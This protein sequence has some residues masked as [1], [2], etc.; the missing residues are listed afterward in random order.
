M[1]QPVYFLFSAQLINITSTNYPECFTTSVIYT[2][3]SKKV[4][5]VSIQ[6]LATVQ[7]QVCFICKCYSL[8]GNFILIKA[9]TSELET[10]REKEKR[11][12]KQSKNQEKFIFFNVADVQQRQGTQF[13]HA[14]CTQT[15]TV[16]HEKNLKEILMNK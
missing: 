12:K 7:A 14:A 1:H 8:Q 10:V 16:K 6:V 11:T 5:Y 15:H 4:N 3:T 9:K 2:S 13:S